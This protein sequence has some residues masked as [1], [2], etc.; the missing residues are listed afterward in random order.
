VLPRGRWRLRLTQ[1]PKGRY[2]RRQLHRCLP[3]LLA[4]HRQQRS[5]ELRAA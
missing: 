3:L 1:Q 4:S 5:Y 2:W